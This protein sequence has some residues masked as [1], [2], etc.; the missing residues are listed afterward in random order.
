M[1]TVKI[2]RETIIQFCK[3]F[4]EHPYRCYTEHGQ[5]ALFYTMLFEALTPE[6]RYADFKGQEV[7]V[8][9]K[10]YPTA[11]RLCKPQRQHWDIAVIKTPAES[12]ATES[13]SYDYLK[14]AEVVEFGMNATRKHL[15]E[16]IRRL[17]HSDANVKNKF[18]VHLYR[19]SKPGGKFSNRDWSSTAN[20]IL[21]R[22]EVT[23]ISR[24]QQVEIFYAMADSTDGHQSGVWCIKQGKA[25]LLEKGW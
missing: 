25:T 7:G 1:P 16:D 15:M 2:V 17:T 20:R 11:D 22:Q 8:I 6:N 9:Q 23:K 18:I 14:L 24:G 19:L 4:I 13:A 21:S 5:H 12:K 10:E 3:D